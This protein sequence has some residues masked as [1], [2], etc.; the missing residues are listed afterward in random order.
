MAQEE[1]QAVEVAAL[2]QQVDAIQRQ[3][4]EFMPRDVHDAHRQSSADRIDNVREAMHILRSDIKAIRT[5][6]EEYKK[7]QA[8]LAL[9]AREREI[10]RQRA[11]IFAIGQGTLA[12]AAVLIN[13][14]FG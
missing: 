9:Q 1:N 5:D 4:A 11:V 12:I 3:L 14:G 2:R 13:I 6:F 8:D 10:S 7:E